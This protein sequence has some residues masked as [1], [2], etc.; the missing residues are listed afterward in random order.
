MNI[1]VLNPGTKHAKNV[2]RDLIYGCWC[3]GKR[4][5]G[6]QSPPLNLLT[7]AT[8]LR[9]DGH[10][11][12]FVDALAERKTIGR[13]KGTIA[14][15][16]MVLINT[17]TMTFREDCLTI[18]KCKEI[19]PGLV[20]VIFGSHPTFMPKESLAEEIDIIVRKEPEFII[21]DVCR[22]IGSG[23]DYRTVRGIGYKRNG[24]A[25]IN[26]DYPFIDLD[27]LP[28]PDRRLLPK[29]TDY[30][31]P[32]VKKV[33][34]TTMITSRGCPAGCTFCTV[35]AFYGSKIRARSA[36]LV[37]EELREIRNQ[38]Y[39]EVWI[40]DETFTVY[41]DRNIRICK[42]II[43]QGL[44]LS[45]MCNARIGT[46]DKQTM[47]LMK[48][49]GCH[50]IK[51]GVESGVQHILDNVRKGI[52]VK[53]TVETFRWAH[54]VGMDTHA[55]MMIGMPGETRES[56]EESIRFAKRI[57]PT[58]ASFAVCTPYAGT[59]LFET[60]VREHPEIRDGSEIEL[61]SVHETS[62]FNQYFT[63]LRRKDLNKA[64]RRAYRSFYLRPVY[65][66]RWLLR[67][68]NTDELRRVAM[69]GANV[70]SFGF[71]RE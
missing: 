61:A 10:S 27:R 66:A 60:V 53:K 1:L 46:V 49:A 22:R 4:I 29:N 2:V 69:A 44:N 31:N 40:R 6:M 26:R 25:V 62:F 18:R 51:F 17:S 43:R 9:N 30:F 57:D 5:G 67:I 65:L 37:L 45:W 58:T 16:D 71:Y 70:F 47:A 34:Y 15:S 12:S 38:G 64:L 68:K 23:R 13:L 42:E 36:E 56:I 59:P 41:R 50:M 19:N 52:S 39:R 20:S 8:I 11:V 33:P 7:V 55:H 32:L 48:Q 54:E 35:P 21:R 3:K 24:R 63:K 28:V 14:K